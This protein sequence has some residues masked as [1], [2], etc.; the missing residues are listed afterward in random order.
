MW[1]GGQV[2]GFWSRLQEALQPDNFPRSAS[3]ENVEV[4]CAFLHVVL[5]LA[6]PRRLS[7]MNVNVRQG[8][9]LCITLA[10]RLHCALTRKIWVY[11]RGSKIFPDTAE[12][13]ILGCARVSKGKYLSHRRCAP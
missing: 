2:E 5:C 12:L 6:E 8:V 3:L 1:A 4:N 13:D 11:I 9:A 7:Q 10:H